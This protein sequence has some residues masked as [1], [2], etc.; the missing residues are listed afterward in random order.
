MTCVQES[1]DGEGR[2]LFEV[3]GEDLAH[4]DSLGLVYDK[5]LFVDRVAEGYGA[6]RPL[7]LSSC[8]RNLVARPLSYHLSLAFRKAHEHI[9]G[10]PSD[11]V[12]RREVLC[13]RHK[14]SSRSSEPL[15]QFREVE[16]LPTQAIDFVDD[17]D[18][19]LP[20]VDVGKEPLEGRPL[21]VCA[22]EAS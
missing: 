22:C 12:C 16:Q 5:S 6:A 4:K 17:H 3:E 2:A 7:S 20:G 8:G 19:D 15:R 11:G 14:G 21:D 10:Q 1:G 9:E 13:D 18:V